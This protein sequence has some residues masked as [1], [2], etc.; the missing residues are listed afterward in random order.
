M[1]TWIQTQA[2]AFDIC[3]VQSDWGASVSIFPLILLF[4]FILKVFLSE[5]QKAKSGNL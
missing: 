3:G 1:E 5:G 2:N 4:L